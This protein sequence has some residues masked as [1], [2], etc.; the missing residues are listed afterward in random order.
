L[1]RDTVIREKGY[2][3]IQL[4]DAVTANELDIRTTC[5]QDT[6][7]SLAVQRASRHRNEQSLAR[8]PVDHLRRIDIRFQ[9]EQRFQFDHGIRSA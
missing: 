9:I 6:R 3:D 1:N 4:G 8:G 5:L 2:T 7:D